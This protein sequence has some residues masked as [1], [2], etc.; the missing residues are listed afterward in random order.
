[1]NTVGEQKKRFPWWLLACGGGCGLLAVLSLIGVIVFVFLG[2]KFF[3][4]GKKERV[5]QYVMTI[6]ANIPEEMEGKKE[7]IKSECDKLQTLTDSG[8]LDFLTFGILE[9]V[10][11]EI[12]EKDK[13]IDAKEMKVL[14]DL[15]EDINRKGGKVNY[16]DYQN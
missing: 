13:S 5:K 10:F 15:I 7:N 4:F 11:S 1:M 2:G 8:K 14:M 16:T 6:K 12:Y 9:N 3:D